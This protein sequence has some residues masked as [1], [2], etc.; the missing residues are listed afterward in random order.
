MKW[1]LMVKKECMSVEKDNSPEKEI[2]EAY[3]LGLMSSGLW[4]EWAEFCQTEEGIKTRR[5]LRRR[6]REWNQECSM[7]GEE[8]K[9]GIGE[10]RTFLAEAL[11]AEQEKAKRAERKK[12]G[13]GRKGKKE[14]KTRREKE[15]RKREKSGWKKSVRTGAGQV[16]QPVK[17]KNA[18]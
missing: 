3:I 15:E 16:S 5:D 9:C 17:F 6:F 13:S 8:M 2:G 11:E 12:E 18:K 1:E 14:K 7:F 4:L 10:V